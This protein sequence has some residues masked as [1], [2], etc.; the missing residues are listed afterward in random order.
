MFDE[1]ADCMPYYDPEQKLCFLQNNFSAYE[2]DWIFEEEVEFK[3]YVTFRDTGIDFKGH[4]E[5]YGDPVTVKNTI[6]FTGPVETHNDVTF[7]TDDHDD[8]TF[9]GHG[10]VFFKDDLNVYSQDSVNWKFEGHDNVD[11]YNNK[12][13]IGTYERY[14]WKNRLG[15][16]MLHLYPGNFGSLLTRI[17][18]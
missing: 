8:I 2:G 12:V 15:L 10:N 1:D 6:K 3:D 5:I 13:T 9:K 18:F 14:V 7:Y 4:N 16:P 17:F 11:F